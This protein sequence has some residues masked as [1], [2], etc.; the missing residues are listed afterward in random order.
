M[1][2]IAYFR[3][4]PKDKQQATLQGPVAPSTITTNEGGV[5]K[6]TGS[7]NY[8]HEKHILYEWRGHGDAD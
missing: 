6:S 3:N 5:Y 8:Q 7:V 2:L 4:G 1:K